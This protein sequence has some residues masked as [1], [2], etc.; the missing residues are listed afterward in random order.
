[1]RE[2]ACDMTWI[3]GARLGNDSEM[4]R[5]RAGWSGC[6]RGAGPAG[7][8]YDRERGTYRYFDYETG[9]CQVR[10]FYGFTDY[11]SVTESVTDS[12]RQIVSVPE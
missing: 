9:W 4:T 12:F 6:S 5:M 3:E 8:G 10:P 1:M 11:E 2:D 7:Q